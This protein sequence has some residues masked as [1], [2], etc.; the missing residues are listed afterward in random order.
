MT[1]K[2]KKTE[3]FRPSFHFS[4]C[5]VAPQQDKS[6]VFI[7][8]RTT[9]RQP[10]EVG[11]LKINSCWCFFPLCGIK[12]AEDIILSLCYPCV[13]DCVLWLTTVTFDIWPPKSTQFTF[14]SKWE[15]EG[16]TATSILWYRC[17]LG[18][19]WCR[20]NNKMM[21]AWRKYG[22]RFVLYIN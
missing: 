11:Y 6:Q 2:W 19:H 22:I 4:N 21:T 8:V 12:P 18:Y 20:G 14:E 13:L 7:R 5:C 17:D 10:A 15:F 9:I 1:L 16:D 3:I